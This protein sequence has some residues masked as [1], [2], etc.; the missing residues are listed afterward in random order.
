MRVSRTTEA[1]ASR[2]HRVSEHKPE[3][4][5]SRRASLMADRRLRPRENA[6]HRP[7]HVPC[8]AASR[9]VRSHGMQIKPAVLRENPIRLD[10][11]GAV[12]PVM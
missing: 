7:A 4:P 9:P 10:F 2:G 3:S 5:K 1:T 11:A 8:V 12:P 6:D